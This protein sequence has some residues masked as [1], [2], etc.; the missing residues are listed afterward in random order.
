MQ[1]HADTNLYSAF[2]QRFPADLN[3]AL[4]TTPEG[5]AYSYA[6][7]ELLSARVANFLV[8]RGF[9]PGDRVTVQ[10]EKSPEM[11]WLYLGVLRAG[12]VF[13]PLNTAYT[14]DELEYFLA[15]ADPA[16]VVCDSRRADD[17]G[18]LCGDARQLLT[19][20]ADGGGSLMS[21]VAHC[22]DTFDTRAEGPEA[23]AA[24]LYSSGTTGKPKG[25][26]LTHGNLIANARVLVDYWGFSA[27]DRLLH[28]LPVFHV[29]GLFVA[30][31][32][33]LMSGASMRWLQRFDAGSV[34]DELVSCTVMMGVPTYYTRLLAESDV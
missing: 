26:M 15:D 17:L 21:A 27:S 32:C 11:L 8:D 2:R 19:L 16:L 29:H 4:L 25:I 34:I 1:E 9:K 33:V 6:D 7:A 18:A 22:D 24:L 20:D 13:H 14:N 31:G 23:M 28:A 10:V 5:R 30:I 12:L 3:A